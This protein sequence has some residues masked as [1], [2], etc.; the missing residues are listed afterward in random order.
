MNLFHNLNNLSGGF[1]TGLCLDREYA[2]QK[3]VQKLSI[4]RLMAQHEKDLDSLFP[5]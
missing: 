2:E 1:Y 4:S 3:E 5:S